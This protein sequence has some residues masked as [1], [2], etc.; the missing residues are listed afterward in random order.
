MKEVLYEDSQMQ[1]LCIGPVQ[2]LVLC[3]VE[4]GVRSANVH[5]E[6]EELQDPESDRIMIFISCRNDQS[7]RHDIGAIEDVCMS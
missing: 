4:Q 5:K 2:S 7:S 3:V 6:A 1:S